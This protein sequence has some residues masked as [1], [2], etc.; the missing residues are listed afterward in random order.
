MLV[1]SVVEIKDS[2]A[3]KSDVYRTNNMCSDANFTHYQVENFYH[4]K[5]DNRFNNTSFT[6]KPIESIA[7]V[8]CPAILS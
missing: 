8:L 3:E 4:D 7:S 1:V 5:I 6:N 2:L